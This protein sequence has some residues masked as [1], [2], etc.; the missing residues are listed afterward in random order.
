MPLIKS[1]LYVGFVVPLM[2]VG[3]DYYMSP[4]REYQPSTHIDLKQPQISSLHKF[5]SGSKS[6]ILDERGEGTLNFW[7]WDQ[8]LEEQIE[9]NYQDAGVWTN[10][11]LLKTVNQL[12]YRAWN[13]LEINTPAHFIQI[14]MNYFAGFCPSYIAVVDKN[15]ASG[16]EKIVTKVEEFFNCPRFDRGS[17]SIR[18]G[19]K[20]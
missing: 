17:L 8:N 7:G 15:E 11:P 6:K 9:I 3:V 2:M 12:K 20:L 1:A 16:T 5:K 19:F 4:F 18:E 13:I 14:G 10:T